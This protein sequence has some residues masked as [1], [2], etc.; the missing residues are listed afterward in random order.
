MGSLRGLIC[1]TVIFVDFRFGRPGDWLA[2]RHYFE[3][4]ATGAV[5][6]LLPTACLVCGSEWWQG[7]AAQLCTLWGGTAQK[8]RMR[9]SRSWNWRALIWETGVRVYG[10]LYCV[11]L[12][13]W[14]VDTFGLRLDGA[15]TLAD[16]IFFWH[17]IF[18][19]APFEKHSK[20]GVILSRSSQS[21][22]NLKF[23]TMLTL[24]VWRSASLYISSDYVFVC[25]RQVALVSSIKCQCVR[26]RGSSW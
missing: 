2:G 26:R 10:S 23:D 7:L 4:R 16:C 14:Y 12:Q 3:A 1:L 11:Q 5:G 8:L 25:Q 24:V 19:D 17:W 22:E 15:G 9:D 21:W 18:D 20:G 13:H 6:R